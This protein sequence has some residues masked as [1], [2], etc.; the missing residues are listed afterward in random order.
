MRSSSSR[1]GN[2]WTGGSL[3]W[4]SGN[5]VILCERYCYVTERERE[6]K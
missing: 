2:E 4:E 5:A 3:R 1:A 6:R